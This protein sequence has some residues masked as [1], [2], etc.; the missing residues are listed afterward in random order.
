MR[1]TEGEKR[2]TAIGNGGEM[3]QSHFRFRIH[4]RRLLL[5]V[6]RKRARSFEIG[7]RSGGQG[8][9][10][11]GDA[12]DRMRQKE[13]SRLGGFQPAMSRSRVHRR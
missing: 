11:A 7:A 4:S 10:G 6:R 9:R 3:S 2:T 5:L 8:S 12:C 1:E 13:S